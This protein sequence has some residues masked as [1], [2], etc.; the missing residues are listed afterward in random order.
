MDSTSSRKPSIFISAGEA[1]RSRVA[2]DTCNQQ[3]A[4]EMM[5]YNFGM[6]IQCFV[7]LG[8]VP[9]SCGV[10]NVPLIL[11]MNQRIIAIRWT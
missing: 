1:P 4:E 6:A 5:R 11:T 2:E 8:S 3:N 10:H 7:K 9:P